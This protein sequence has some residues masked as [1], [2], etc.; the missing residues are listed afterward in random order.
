ME[1]R[2]NRGR[3]VAGKSGNPKGRPKHTPNKQ[4]IQELVAATLPEVITRLLDLVHSN[5]ET[6][7]LQAAIALRDWHSSKPRFELAGTDLPGINTVS[8]TY[9]GTQPRIAIGDYNVPNLL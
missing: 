7:A 5:D 9:G 6:I 1:E 4:D 8:V 2:D 3:F